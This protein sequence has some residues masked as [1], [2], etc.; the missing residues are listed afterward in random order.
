LLISQLLLDTNKWLQLEFNSNSYYIDEIGGGLQNNHDNNILY[1]TSLR[2]TL[3]HLV[4]VRTPSKE[5]KIKSNMVH[6]LYISEDDGHRRYKVQTNEGAVTK[7]FFVPADYVEGCNNIFRDLFND[8]N[9]LQKE[10][11]LY[12]R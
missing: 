3:K 8:F 2:K 7:Q 11:N 1:Y 12:S 5:F 9:K 10:S 4:F 6:H